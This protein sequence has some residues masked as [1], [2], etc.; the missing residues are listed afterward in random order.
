MRTLI[1]DNY[2]SFTFNLFQLIATVNGEEPIVVRNDQLAWRALE[3]VAFDNIVISP[4]PGTV[5]REQDFGICKAA[6]L[7]AP[8]P[9]LGVCLG[10]QGIGH[11]YGG[12]I[13]HAPEP[14]HGRLS[15]VFHDGSE[16]FEG[17][18]QGF[19]AVRYHS[20]L[21]DNALPDCLQR[22]AWT[23]DGIMMALR[24]RSLPIWGVQFHPESISSEYGDRLLRNFR[25]LTHRG[26]RARPAG[27]GRGTGL[28]LVPKP[29]KSGRLLLTLY[30][31]AVSTRARG[32]LPKRA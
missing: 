32:A 18:P 3:D 26:G 24:H 21:V 28:S 9:I 17:V 27:A 4:G 25:D 22:T 2:D 7:A 14:M 5:E 13:R 8:V 1:I 16:L 29:R 20:L 30:G 15:A 19:D 11:L 10:H 23:E 12:K 31:L 6:L